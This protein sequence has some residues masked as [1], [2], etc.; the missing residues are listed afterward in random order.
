MTDFQKRLIDVADMNEATKGL[1]N[2]EN[3]TRLETFSRHMLKINEELNLTAIC[4]DEGVI[5]KHLVDSSAIVPYIKEGA[6]VA[7]IGCG[8][9]FPTFPISILR[10]DITVLGVDSVTKKVEY[11]KNTATLLHI[12][13]ISVSNRRAEELGKDKSYREQFDVVCARAVGKL[14]LLCELCIPLCKVG[15]TFIAMK[16]RTTKE[17]LVEAENAI[18]LLGATCE[19]IIDYT[20]T[21]GEESLERTIVI[22]KKQ[23]RTPDKYP[24]NNSQISKKPL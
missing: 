21:N 8:G 14:N 1:I 13:G 15:G 6:K 7:D 3:A 19:R 18:S 10:P 12:P 20:L 11:V 4:D 16:S 2:E 23:T 24:R 5:L 9:G 22:I 17:E